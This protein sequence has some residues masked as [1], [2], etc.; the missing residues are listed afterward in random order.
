M[1]TTRSRRERGREIEFGRPMQTHLETG[2]CLLAGP[3]QGCDCGL[4][5][6]DGVLRTDLARRMWEAHRDEIL[7]GWTSTDPPWGSQF[8]S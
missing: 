5:G 2:D 7:A 4:R 3:G 6:S 8:D 1:T